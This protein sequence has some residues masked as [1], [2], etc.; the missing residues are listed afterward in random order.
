LRHKVLVADSPKNGGQSDACE[1]TELSAHRC[2]EAM[3]KNSLTR[4]GRAALTGVAWAA[5]WV[6]IGAIVGWLIV[7][8]LEPEW[9]G[10]PVYAGFLC[11]VIFAGVSGASADGLGLEELSLAQAGARGA[12]SGLVAGGLWLIV[13]LLSDPPKWLFEASVVAGLTA[14]SAV[15]G[16]GSALL[17][18]YTR[19]GAG[20]HAR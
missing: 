14:L 5:A 12:L 18:R 8:E 6:P 13:A 16:L 19:N 20:A 9:I 11:G 3:M 1:V 2:Q 7:G 10:G 4:F 17:A 15:T